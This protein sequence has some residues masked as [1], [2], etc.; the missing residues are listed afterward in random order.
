MAVFT[1]PSRREISLDISSMATSDPSW[2]PLADTATQAQCQA[3][4]LTSAE[5]DLLLLFSYFAS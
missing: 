5:F 3:K 4:F 2:P 1:I